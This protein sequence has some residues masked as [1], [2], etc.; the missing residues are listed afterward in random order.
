MTTKKAK[1]LGNW[2]SAAASVS[3]L[4]L[5]IAACGS[6]ESNESKGATSSS[7]ETALPAALNAQSCESEQGVTDDTINIGVLTDLSGPVSAGG[8]IDIGQ[9]FKA[10]FDAI[11]AGGGID[12]RKIEVDIEDM[13]YDPVV[14]AQAYENL[15]ADV[16]MMPIILSSSGIDA[17]GQ[18]MAEDCLLTFQGGSNGVIAQKYATAFS[19]ITSVGHDVT[20]AISWALEQNSEATFAIALQADATGAQTADA[21]EFAKEEL[22]IT[23]KGT[24]SFASSDTDLTAQVQSLKE[25]DPTYVIFGG[26]VPNQ[27]A[28]LTSGLKAAGS[29]TKFLVSTSGW[30]PNVLSTPAAAA[31]EENVTVMTGYG[32]WASEDPGIVKMRKELEEHSERELKPGTPPLLG[33]QAAL[34]AEE[35]LRI[36]SENGDL[37][38]GGIYRA[39][40]QIEDLDTEGV[41]PS[42]TYG[43]EN[44]P[45][46][47]STASRPYETDAEVAGGLVPLTT[48]Y[49]DSDLSKNYIEPKP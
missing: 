23:V 46:I 42:L 27:L 7:G 13:K 37:T 31:I 15:R 30:A 18:D 36:A 20:N 26:G 29:S 28:T 34:A 21:V 1:Q 22:G 40:M 38:L 25:M 47:P 6:S 48:D 4:A 43:R 12:G 32:A 49:L 41:S 10:H 14:T 17:V 33:Y 19:P 9:A 3:V 2:R 11:N 35:A 8:G 24:V 39:T 16:A 5:G 44:E 45:R